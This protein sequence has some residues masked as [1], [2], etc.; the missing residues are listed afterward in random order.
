MQ[1][2]FRQNRQNR[3][4]LSSHRC[5]IT[6]LAKNFARLIF[7]KILSHIRQISRFYRYTDVQIRK[8]VK[9][10]LKLVWSYLKV[11]NC[12]VNIL[13]VKNFAHLKI[14]DGFI[15]RHFFILF[16]IKTVRHFLRVYRNGNKESSPW[17]RLLFHRKPRKI[18]PEKNLSFWHTVQ[19][20]VNCF[21]LV[22]SFARK[23]KIEQPIREL[24][25]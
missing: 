6:L 16:K 25:I 8:I 23:F 5:W 1:R 3:P 11:L 18:R 13:D 20:S 21:W 24:G 9:Q 12:T 15:F 7:G 10:C 17:K 2:N 14:L 4:K 19:R 22:D